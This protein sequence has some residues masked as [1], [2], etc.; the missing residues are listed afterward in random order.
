NVVADEAERVVRAVQDRVVLDVDR[1]RHVLAVGGVEPDRAYAEPPV[2]VEG[3][4]ADQRVVGDGGRAG[5]WHGGEPVADLD[6]ATLSDGVGGVV[7]GV[8]VVPAAVVG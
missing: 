1:A 7:V 6:A 8:G 5:Q 4:G 2:W 3:T